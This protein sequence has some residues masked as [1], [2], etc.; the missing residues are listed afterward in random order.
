MPRK[1][2][3]EI[4]AQID[5]RL[6]FVTFTQRSSRIQDYLLTLLN[7]PLAQT[8]PFRVR[9]FIHEIRSGDFA[10]SHE[11]KKT[12]VHYRGLKASFVKSH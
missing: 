9:L 11:E 10:S 8:L 5:T 2:I 6:R 3:W 1:N 4:I 7:V 12:A